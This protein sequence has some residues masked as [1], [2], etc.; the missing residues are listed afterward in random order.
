MD[1]FNIDTN[2]LT[3]ILYALIIIFFFTIISSFLAYILIK[4]F[5]LKEKNNSKIKKHAFYK[6]MKLFFII[7]GVYIATLF[8]P[9]PENIK[10]IIMKIFKICIIL[11]VAKGFANLFDSDSEGFE[12]LKSKLKLNSNSGVVNFTSRILKILVY[13]IAGFIVITELGYNL[14]GLVTGL[15]ISSVVIALAAQDLAKSLFGGICIILDKP[16]NIGDYISVNNYEGTVEDITLRTT[17]IRNTANELIIVPNS[18]ISADF[19]VNYSRRNSRRYT[20]DLVL[21]LSTPISK[22]ADFK[23]S[24]LELFNSNPNIL[25]QDIRIFFDTISDNG[26]NFNISFYANV[27]N[28]NDFLAF[29][30]EINF[31][32][33]NL[34]NA[35]NIELA[36]DSKTIYLKK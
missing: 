28:Y 27:V 16:F 6:P 33:L 13:I 30:E 11:L 14:N 15:G 9:I 35:Q 12:K 1:N 20:L 32:I 2:L 4:M 7:I 29:K 3:N 22:V 19:I 8:F 18:E 24:L 34:A 31:E 17:R 23:A 26:I 21:D 5:H 25:K 10:L 36:Y